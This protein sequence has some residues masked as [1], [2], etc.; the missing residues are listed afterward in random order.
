VAKNPAAPYRPGRSEQWLKLKLRQEGEFVIG[1]CVGA[2]G[3]LLVGAY[4]ENGLRFVGEV[5]FGLTPV[6][7]AE[8]ARLF[9][10]LVAP[11]S[12]FV[13][14]QRKRG[15][16]WL[17][18]RLVFEVTFQEW[19]EGCLRHPCLRRVAVERRADECRLT[20]AA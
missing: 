11:A 16:T 12:P 20:D 15:A 9:E 19:L 18:P 10:P 8:L 4:E 14:L 3:S 5:E 17:A 13:N 1:G 7:R 6:L 2:V